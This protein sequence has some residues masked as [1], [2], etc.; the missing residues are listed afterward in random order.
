VVVYLYSF[1]IEKE[2][3]IVIKDSAV[4]KEKLRGLLDVGADATGSM[5]DSQLES[6][7]QV[8]NVTASS[9]PLQKEELLHAH[10]E[11]DFPTVFQWL[12]IINSGLEE[13]HAEALRK[14]CTKFLTINSDMDNIKQARVKVFIDYFLPSLDLFFDDVHNV[15]EELEVEEVQPQI[16][17]EEPG[18]VREKLLTITELNSHDIKQMLD[19]DLDEYLQAVNNFHADFQAQENGL[20]GSLK[21]K[22][23]VFVLQWLNAIHETLVKI[24]A[25]ELAND[26]KN[27]IEACKDFNNIRHEKLEVFINYFMST[28]S[29][30]S[31][32]IKMLHLPKKLTLTGENSGKPEHIAVEVE[33]LSPGSSPDAKTV[34][35]INKMMM[36]MN[37][38]KNAL[39]DSG[40]KLIGV[41]T[42][43]ATVGYLKTS[44]PDLFIVDE[45]LQGTDSYV[46]IKLI[47]ATGQMAPIIFTTSKVRK[48]LMA[49]YI[50]A[51]VA[52]FIAKPISPV[53]VQ[54]K[55]AKHLPFNKT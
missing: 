51:G 52:D 17:V 3:T 38:L 42:A 15:L 8:L 41:T 40:H 21:I 14:E 30:L 43:E 32:D 22:H 16:G 1:I 39:N 27:Q 20:R 44:K 2:L 47:R 45:D 6:F 37:S 4:I 49:K 28:L 13:M 11:L 12:N 55:V 26:C 10:S 31:A 25:T 48:D 7:I 5:S 36:F 53:D 18:K 33:L 24:H 34:L 29:M 19:E 9:Y 23:Y 50:E 35:I 46:L 54:K